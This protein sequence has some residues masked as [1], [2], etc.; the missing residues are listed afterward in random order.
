MVSRWPGFI[1]NVNEG[2]DE[3]LVAM[4]KVQSICKSAERMSPVFK[5]LASVVADVQAAVAKPKRR[6]VSLSR[7]SG[8]KRRSGSVRAP[9]RRTL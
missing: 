4:D 7:T 8:R 9:R 3:L 5:Q 1:R 6:T 2:L